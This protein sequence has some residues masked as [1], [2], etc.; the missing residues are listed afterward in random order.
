MSSMTGA[1]SRYFERVAGEWDDLRN[2]YF[3]E[4]VRQAAVEHAYLRP[5]M[6]VADVGAGTGFVAAG[7]APLVKAVHVI[8]GSE[9]MLEVARK[10]LAA[11]PNVLFHRADGL[12]LTLADGSVDVVFANMYLHHCPDPLAAIREMVRILRPGGRLILTDLDRHTNEWMRAEMAD[13]WLGFDRDQ[14]RGWLREAGLVNR[15]VDCT[16]SSCCAE[17]EHP[18]EVDPAGRAAKISVFVAAGSKRVGGVTEAVQAHYGALASSGCGC[19]PVPQP[20]SCCGSPSDGPAPAPA[21]ASSCCAPASTTAPAAPKSSGCCSPVAATTSQASSCC[22]SAPTTG[23][24]APKRSSCCAST[25]VSASSSSTPSGQAESAT[26]YTA[27][28]L[29]SVPPEAAAFSLGCG[30]PLAIS[31]L[32]PGQVVLDIGSGGGID[33]FYAARQVGETGRVIGLDMTPAMIERATRSALDAGLKQ[34]EFRLGQAEAMPVEDGAVDVILSNCVINLCADKG[35]VFAEAYRVLKEGGYLSISDTVTD[36]ALPLDLH[37]QGGQ[38]GE[39]VLGALPEREYVELMRQAGFRDI[40]VRRNEIGGFVAGVHVYSV[41][42]T[43]KKGE[44]KG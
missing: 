13:E 22:G 24:A 17:T 32:R 10:N 26:G 6:T 21:E 33:V 19:G 16:G 38:W 8:D 3:S 9:A 5:E 18:E 20:S 37:Q 29:A 27:E 42:V 36:V 28:Q 39:C 14:V 1:S 43:A 30:N 41:A 35:Q 2:G 31:R 15:I 44:E 34:V 23:P 7:L 4:E 12:S 11:L 25:P 40:Q